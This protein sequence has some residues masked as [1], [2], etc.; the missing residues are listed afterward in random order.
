MK[1]EHWI[2]ISDSTRIHKHDNGGISIRVINNFS[3]IGFTEI[4]LSVEELDNLNV[5]LNY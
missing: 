2:A 4:F 3:V 1:D 5:V